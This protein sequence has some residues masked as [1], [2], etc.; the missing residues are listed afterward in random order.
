[1]Q[2]GELS[3]GRPRTG[4]VGRRDGQGAQRGP[5][6]RVRF[7]WLLAGLSYAFVLAVASG[8]GRDEPRLLSVLGE[9]R[10]GGLQWSTLRFVFLHLVGQVA[11]FLPLGL[12]LAPVTMPA[13]RNRA[14]HRLLAVLLGLVG[15]IGVG[16][17][18]A[19]V[20]PGWRWTIP[21]ALQLAL[22]V[23]GIAFGAFL[24][25]ALRRR[26]GRRLLSLGYRF[27][28]VMAVSILAGYMFGRAL[29]L[30]EPAPLEIV[31]MSSEEKRALVEKLRRHNPF[32][33]PDMQLTNLQLDVH[34]LEG[35]L[36]WAVLLVDPDGRAAVRPGDDA[37]AWRASA[38]LPMG[39]GRHRYL[40]AGGRLSLEADHDGVAAQSCELSVG[41][42]QIPAWVC[43][44]VLRELHGLALSALENPDGGTMPI[45]SIQLDG[46]GLLARYGRLKFDKA[47][48]AR[49][50][51]VTGPDWRVQAAARAQ[52]ERLRR[53]QGDT[54]PRQERFTSLLSG[55]FA[56]AR[57]RSGASNAVVENQGL[58]LALATLFGHPDV[59]V[60]SGI[61]RP[62]DWQA[63]RGEWWPMGLYGRSDWVRHFLVSA[64]IT[65][66]ASVGVS[67]AAGL[68]KEELDAG[69]R[70]GFSFADLLAD[71]AG[72]VFGELATSD[73][74]TAAMLQQLLAE[75]V[76]AGDLMPPA[77]DLPEGLSDEEFERRFGGVG[78]PPY[79][80]VVADIEA[81]VQS[82]R[83]VRELR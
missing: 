1:M 68:L 2:R 55:A 16:V 17:L 50:R 71:R 70:S 3:R 43:R 19:G 67:D 61:E 56:E 79:Q 47:S 27:A 57:D 35:L 6:V 8:F 22:P 42:L 66:A 28:V 23:A 25:G 30:P 76:V 5:V 63:L 39:T 48:K 37:V 72:T 83:I 78:E 34:E 77:S 45:E 46:S 9:L 26:P 40:T 53:L 20:G 75:G 7:G 38:R 62:D 14:A 12:L 13:Q 18:V 80:A 81:R 10:F 24:G 21:G 41:A 82:L 54:M 59:A 64:A 4:R 29:L 11:L 52:F 36:G 73:E 32:R 33:V 69:G 31:Q 44:A 15:A 65:Q 74:A 49:L 58:I 60:L 51:Q